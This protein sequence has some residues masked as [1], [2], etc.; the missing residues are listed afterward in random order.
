MGKEG[1]SSAGE[2]VI[3]TPCALC[4]HS[5]GMNVYVKDGNIV[6]V[7]GMVEHPF[8]KGELCP[9]GQAVLDWQYAPDRLKYPMKRTEHGWHRISWDEALDTIATKLTETKERYGARAVTFACGSIGAEDIMMAAITQR[10]R[11]AFGS[12]NYI[13]AECICFHSLIMSRILTFGRFPLEDPVNSKCIIVWGSNIDDSNFPRARMV[14]EAVRNGAI[15]VVIDP[16][17]TQLAKEGVY[18]QI[19]PG[20]D[21]A[22]AL[23]MANQ[24]ICEG[25]YDKEFVDKWTVG[26][27]KLREHVKQYTPEKAE[28]ITGVAASDIKW[29]ARTFA[30]AR[31][32]CIIQGT[33]AI[34]QQANGIQTMRAMAVLQAITGNYDIPGTW[35]RCPIIRLTDLR[36]PIPEEPMGAD[37]YPLFYEIWGRTFPY[38]QGLSFPDIAL[39]G[40]PYPIKAFIGLATNWAVTFPEARKFVAALKELDFVVIMDI[41]MTETAELAHIVLPAKTFLERPSIGYTY[42]VVEGIPYV[43][44]RKKAVE[45]PGECWSEY[46]FWHELALRMGLEEYFPWQTDEEVSEH[47]LEPSG[48]NWEIL[49][50]KP[51]GV[52]FAEI[53]YKTYERDGFPTPSKKVELYSET[54]EKA[55]FDPLPTYSE[56]TQSP[57]STP[58]LAK[59]YPLILLTG[60]RRKEFTHSQ[61]HNIPQL[62]SAVPEPLAQVHP[63]TLAKYNIT[64]GELVALET[65]KGG[66]KIRV[67]ADEDLVPQAVSIPHGWA[68]AN[69][70]DLTDLEL[71]DDISGFAQLRAILCRLRKI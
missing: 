69:A 11:G 34:D 63:S 9:R 5:C 17:R 28:A 66:I 27:D 4:V 57:I 38:G 43:M 68:Q 60:S 59:E 53:E 42:G 26:F 15:L 13:S 1:L 14:R 44:S 16:K 22:L 39:S 46:E 21:G 54:L 19:R 36:L 29:L 12:P 41:F 2:Q 10:F 65:P 62:R 58:G 49:S 71:R 35:I 50:Q 67:K 24:I 47:L 51:S 20:S 7:E 48:V 31:S 6:R 70:N 37:K 61:F 40:K 30:S 3:K 55:G 32:A 18:F 64:D 25:L 23:A 8:N 33:N 52:Y 45:A 56:P